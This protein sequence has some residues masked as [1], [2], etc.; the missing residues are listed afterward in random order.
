MVL[1]P[2]FWTRHARAGLPPALANHCA[3][4]GGRVTL[5][6]TGELLPGCVTVGEREHF[7]VRFGHARMTGKDVGTSEAGKEE[8]SA[9]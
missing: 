8:A 2:G 7:A 4:S 6:A 1:A 3:G 9:S 5:K